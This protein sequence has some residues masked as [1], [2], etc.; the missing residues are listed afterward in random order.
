VDVSQPWAVRPDTYVTIT[1][2]GHRADGTARILDGEQMRCRAHL[3]DDND[4]S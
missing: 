2:S 1:C 3:V 4:T